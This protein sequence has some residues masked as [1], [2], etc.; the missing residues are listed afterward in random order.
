MA[1]DPCGPR[2]R[3]RDLVLESRDLAQLAGEQGWLWWRMRL[4]Y[5]RERFCLH[6]LH[7]GANLA[8]AL[9]KSLQIGQTFQVALNLFVRAYFPV[10]FFWQGA[11]GSSSIAIAAAFFVLF[12]LDLSYAVIMIRDIKQP[13]LC[14][15]PA[16]QP[17]CRKFSGVFFAQRHPSLCVRTLLGRLSPCTGRRRFGGP[18]NR[19]GVGRELAEF[20]RSRPPDGGCAASSAWHLRAA[21]RRAFA[22]VGAQFLP[23]GACGHKDAVAGCDLIIR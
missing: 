9:A 23:E 14:S 3:R 7:N 18:G 12:V 20:S 10:Y 13:L 19:G 1:T 15:G 2:G 6:N 11:H 22:L 5:K 16:V 4:P 8:L 21:A 17:A